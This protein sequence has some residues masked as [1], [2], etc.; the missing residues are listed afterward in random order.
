MNTE[1]NAREQ[2]DRIIQQWHQNLVPHTRPP[3]GCLHSLSVA[4]QAVLSPPQHHARIPTENGYEDVRV[5]GTLQRT[6]DGCVLGCEPSIVLHLPCPDGSVLSRTVERFEQLGGVRVSECFSTPKLSQAALAAQARGE[7]ASSTGGAG[8]ATPTGSGESS[9]DPPPVLARRPTDQPGHPPGVRPIH[10]GHGRARQGIPPPLPKGCRAAADEIAILQDRLANIES[11]AGAVV[12]Q[13]F[14]IRQI[15]GLIDDW[16]STRGK[17]IDSLP[18]RNVLAR[19]AD[20]L[21]TCHLSSAP[22][23]DAASAPPASSTCSG[24]DP[25]SSTRSSSP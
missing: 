14:I 5:L 22:T 4:L 6:K 12:Q 23:A 17:P 11:R 1:T 19:I 20:I 7:S 2:V 21:E 13:R 18:D 25:T 9:H 3:P 15:T 8:A 24:P 16:N 10:P